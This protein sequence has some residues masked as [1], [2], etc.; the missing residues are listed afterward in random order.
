[1]CMKRQVISSGK[2]Y[3]RS[4]APTS[5]LDP[6]SSPR[7]K[8]NDGDRRTDF[9]ITES[10]GTER[11]GN[12]SHTLGERV[13]KSTIQRNERNAFSREWL[14]EEDILNLMCGALITALS[15]H[16][17]DCNLMATMPTDVRLSALLTACLTPS[18]VLGYNTQW[19]L[20]CFQTNFKLG[21]VCNEKANWFQSVLNSQKRGRAEISQKKV[22]KKQV[23]YVGQFRELPLVNCHPRTD[24]SDAYS[25]T[26][27]HLPR[28]ETRAERI[29]PTKEKSLILHWPTYVPHQS[30]RNIILKSRVLKSDGLK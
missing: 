20:L 16:Q 3:S 29:S 25:D 4:A 14:E 13:V 6:P 10:P 30:V 21:L 15:Q 2:P 23:I 11:K 12:L 17:R 22:E 24:M 27:E 18:E 7:K 9:P 19:W 5:T 28:T 8:H 26:D 1:M